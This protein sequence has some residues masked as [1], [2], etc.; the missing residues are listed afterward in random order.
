MKLNTEVL[1]TL[2]MI[3][4]IGPAAILAVASQIEKPVT[5]LDDLVNVWATLKPCKALPA[6][7]LEQI[8]EDVLLDAHQKALNTLRYYNQEGIGVISYFDEAFPQ[9]LRDCVDESGKCKPPFFLFYRGNLAAL[10]KPGIAVIGTREPTANGVKAGRYFA[11]QYAEKG[12]NI[13]SGLALGC[14]T[15]GHRGALDAGGVTT[16]FLATD[17]SW[18]SIYPKENLELAKEIVEKGGLLLSEY[19]LGT[20]LG[21]SNFIERDRLQAGLAQATL[22]VQTGIKSGTMHAVR[23]T[24]QAHKPLLA[25]Q[26]K[27]DVDL[28]DENVQGNI[29]LIESGTAKPL[30]SDNI[31]IV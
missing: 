3:K 24:L 12:Y 27:Y 20:P 5:T 16:A 17:L 23:A 14:D 22:V 29:M 30:N 13:V 15:S 10:N 9:S 26:Y 25:V 2:K 7:K 1:L 31:P 21:R 18:K 6:K 19:A 4:G 11:R 28:K 8:T